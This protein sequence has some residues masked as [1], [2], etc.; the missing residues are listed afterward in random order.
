MRSAF[1]AIPCVVADAAWLPMRKYRD[2]INRVL[3]L[4]TLVAALLVSS[5]VRAAEKRKLPDYDGR[6]LPDSTGRKLLWIPRV[7]LFPVY[8]VSEYGIRWPLGKLISGAEQAGVP[9][10]LYDFF[11]FGPD[12]K[13]GVFPTVFA[14]SGFQPSFGLYA[15]WDDA[16][17][18]GHDLRARASFSGNNWISVGAAERYRYSNNPLDRIGWDVSLLR[19][20]DYLYFGT[21]PLTLQSDALR[22]GMQ[23][24]QG[25]GVVE[26]R[27]WRMSSFNAQVAVRDVNYR[28]GLGNADG[29]SV[30]NA[31][32]AGIIQPPALIDRGYTEARSELRAVLDTR[33]PERPASGVRLQANLRHSADLKNQ[34]SWVRYGGIAGGFVDLDGHHRVLSLAAGARFVD[35]V[36]DSVVPFTELVALGGDSE[37]LVG[38]YAGRLVGRSAAAVSLTYRWPIWVWLDGSLRFELGNVFD[39][40]LAEV[41]PGLLRYSGAV[42]IES[43]T[44][45][46]SEFQAVLGFGSNP[47]EAG[48]QIDSVRLTIGTSYD[49]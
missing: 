16:G 49:F 26:H 32:A 47:F 30:Q 35:P 15:F 5:G 41:R 34:G 46:E 24:F 31:L 11:A 7:L 6:D 45:G 48:G 20:P 39:K 28:F 12:H 33:N 36:G 10:L 9:A 37:A 38:F 3:G 42:A 4:S 17:F 44:K 29:P 14:D 8:V 18:R 27:F 43:R 13:A 1:I 25:R 22:Y 2:G 40:H 21:G 19:R 23:T